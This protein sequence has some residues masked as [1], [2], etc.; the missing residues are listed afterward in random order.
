M[1][2]SE[3][4]LMKLSDHKRSTSFI[5]KSTNLKSYGELHQLLIVPKLGVAAVEYGGHHYSMQ[6]LEVSHS[7]CMSP[8]KLWSGRIGG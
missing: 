7:Q 5:F 1:H 2:H 3:L 8:L 6:S 4:V